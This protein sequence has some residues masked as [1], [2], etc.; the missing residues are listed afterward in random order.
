MNKVRRLIV[1]TD[2]GSDDAVAVIMALRDRS[3]KVEAFTTVAGNVGIEQATKNCLISIE[4]AGT[5]CPPV[6][7]GCEKPI[8]KES[9]KINPVVHGIDGMGDIGL[10][11]PKIKPETVHA[12]DFLIDYIEKYPNEIELVTIG[13]VTNLALICHKSPGTLK[14]VKKIWMMM[15]TGL[16]F[17]NSTPLSE[18]NAQMDPE[19]LDIVLR[20]AGT[21]IYLLGWDLCINEYLFTEED[22]TYLYGTGSQTAK[23][24]LDINKLLM[25]LNV[26][27]FGKK[28]ID[29]ADPVAMA[30][31]LQPD[32]IEKSYTAYTRCETNK[33]IAYGAIAVDSF[34]QSGR[35]CNATTVTKINA[36]KMKKCICDLII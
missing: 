34:H 36:E 35:K 23:F 33:G 14:K 4:M 16:Y 3:V 15:G 8:L 25:D 20:Y 6:Y 32:I 30:I 27:R 31:A 5:Y 10:R 17:G 13:P 26:K 9:G 22:I 1:D 19:A 11:K 29:F 2:T 28:S 24:C 18:G 7:M 12:V 21:P